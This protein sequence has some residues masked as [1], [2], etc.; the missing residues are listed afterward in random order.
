MTAPPDLDAAFEAKLAE[1]RRSGAEGRSSDAATPSSLG[2]LFLSHRHPE[3]GSETPFGDR[4]VQVGTRW[5]CRR[6]SLLYPIGTVVAFLFAF[7]VGWPNSW[8]MTAIW[9]LCIP[10]TVAYCGEALG[11][12]AYN[13]RVQ[14][15]AMAVSAL[16]FG[17]GLGYEFQDRWSGQFWWPVTV[18]GG[19]WFFST[20]IGALRHKR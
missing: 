16:G 5:V 4:C 6:C 3:P 8:D 12:F 11:L 17:R 19:L 15:A 18:F 10:A 2:E 1:I 20:L 7:G 13:A 14:S 9:L